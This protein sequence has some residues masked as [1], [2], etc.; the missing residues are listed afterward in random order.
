[1]LVNFAA[2]LSL[3]TA[4]VLVGAI[5]FQSA[6][7]APSVF[8]QLDE[9]QARRFLRTLFPRLFRLGVI[10]AAVIGANAIVLIAASERY[11]LSMQLLLGAALILIFQTASLWLVP[12]INRARDAGN[13]G[14]RRF[15]RLHRLSVGLSLATLVVSCLILGV[16]GLASVA[17]PGI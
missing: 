3:I 13:A 10:C 9:Q 15:N 2:I 6:V 7:V 1:M 8:S 12:A 11:L 16:F 17:T 4:A 5:F 14:L